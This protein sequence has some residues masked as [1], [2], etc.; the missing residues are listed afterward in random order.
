M[1]LTF[2]E[3][4]ESMLNGEK[5]ALPEWQGYWY[6]DNGTILIHT[7]DGE[8]IDIRETHDVLYT[9]NNVVREDWLVI[10]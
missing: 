6:V 1:N 8:E 4:Y 7:A 9:F 10:K 3:A 2:K 5:I